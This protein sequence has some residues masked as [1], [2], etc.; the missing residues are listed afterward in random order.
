MNLVI[1]LYISLSSLPSSSVMA[2][3]LVRNGAKV[4]IA[5]RKMPQI[6]KTSK[7]LSEL[8]P[9]DSGI[10]GPA[11]IPLT[12]DVSTKAGCDALAD[13]LKQR[14]SNLDI[15]INNAGATWGAP[16]DNFPE[17]KGWDR[18]FN[19]NVKSQFYLTVA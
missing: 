13:Q 17:D 16:M 18:T 1:S 7:Q 12:A 3:A 15:L 5:S 8:S 9:S 14:E 4:Y 10:S 2:A 11:C 19:L 6:E